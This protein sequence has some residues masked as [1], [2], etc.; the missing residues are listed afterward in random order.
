MFI[1]QISFKNESYELFFTFHSDMKPCGTKK[2]VTTKN[3]NDI[4][5]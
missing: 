3:K 4:K 5:A 2:Q 1:K